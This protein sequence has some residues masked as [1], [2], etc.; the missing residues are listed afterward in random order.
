M[1]ILKWEDGRTFH[2]V[3][4]DDMLVS[5]AK[6]VEKQSGTSFTDLLFVDLMLARTLV[7]LRRNNIM[8]TWRDADSWRMGWITSMVEREPGD[9]EDDETDQPEGD[10][11]VPTST[12]A[13]AG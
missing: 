8:L 5:E 7:T 1:A 6:W 10:A 3:D 12:G 13:E 11:E 2:L 4:R 9:L